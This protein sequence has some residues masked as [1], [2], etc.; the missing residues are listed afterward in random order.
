MRTLPIGFMASKSA[1]A[2]VLDPYTSGLWSAAGL[3]RLLTSYTGPLIRVRRSSDDAEQ[4]IGY[5]SSGYVDEAALLVFAGAGSAYVVRAYDQSGGANHIE[6]STNTNQP[7]IVSSGVYD[8][9]M[10]FDGA[11]DMLITANATP[12]SAGLTLAGRYKLRAAASAGTTQTIIAQ[13]N[14]TIASHCALLFQQQ[15]NT[16]RY[17]SYIFDGPSAYLNVSYSNYTASEVSDVLVG[18]NSLSGTSKL[19]QWRNGSSVSAFTSG[20]PGVSAAAFTSERVTIGRYIDGGQPAKM[21]GKWFAIWQTAQN[22]NAA[23]ISAA[24]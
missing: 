17:D 8:G 16:G 4:D 21:D 13:E 14:A 11:N 2:G 24:L 22:A 1:F 12:A 19:A 6:Q 18:N 3:K 9:A 20:G 5:T 10:V 23:D 7:R 15:H